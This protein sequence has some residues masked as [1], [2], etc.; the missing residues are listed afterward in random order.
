[1]NYSETIIEEAIIVAGG[2]GTR[3]RGVLKDIPKP[4]ADINGKPFLDYLI[5][6]LA[7]KGIKRFILSL[8][9]KAD[10]IKNYFQNHEL[11]DS[12]I[13]SVE[14]EPLG[15]GGGIKKAL[16]G[17]GGKNLLVANGDTFFDVDI[18][19][20]ADFHNS[21]NSDVTLA[22][23]KMD[24]CSRYGVV[25]INDM[26]QIT[27]FEEKKEGLKGYINGG[28][29]V[30]NR[31]ILNGMPER[32]SFEK[33]FLTHQFSKLKMYGYPFDGYFI[34]IGVPE[35]YE[36]AKNEFKEIEIR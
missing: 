6:S 15:T 29:I 16:N 23:K 20:E 7:G 11:K 9:Y 33:D 13:Y 32:F 12:I 34:D 26:M 18:Q 10:Y 1:M 35:D 8:G 22:L 4:M 31:N 25:K 30:I 36:R 5:K 2:F 21:N 27:G 19:K 3:M 28:V 24:N 14:N 17:T